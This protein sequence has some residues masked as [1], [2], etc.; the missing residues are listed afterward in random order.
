MSERPK[1]LIT[2][3]GTGVGAA[4]ALELTRRG[5][6]VL[7]NYRRSADEA[8]SVAEQ[9]RQAGGEPLLVQGDVAEDA[10]CRR[11]VQSALDTW[12]RLDALVNNAG[13][14]VF[15]PGQWD[16][17]EP[18]DFQRL[19]AVNTIGTG[20]VP[21]RQSTSPVWASRSVPWTITTPSWL[22]HRSHA[23]SRISR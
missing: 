13:V 21:G 10:D 20:G 8:N 2:G 12:G 17:L 23:L 11:L 22:L 19:Y 1:A 6:D 3:A 16:G 5:Y 18:E 7:I 4:T 14:T 9:C 15:K